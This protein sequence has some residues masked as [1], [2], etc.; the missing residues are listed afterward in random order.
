VHF[1]EKRFAKTDGHGVLFTNGT[2]KTFVGLGIIKRMVREGKKNGLIVVPSQQIL[3]A[4]TR[5]AGDLGLT[6][7]ALENIKDHGKGVAITIYANLAEND[8]LADRAHDFP[9][10]FHRSPEPQIVEQIPARDGGLGAK[11][12]SV[13]TSRYE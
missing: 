2:G 11:V 12:R 13:S 9:N 6:L 1:A 5:A 4:W 8:T 3:N 10:S 7:N